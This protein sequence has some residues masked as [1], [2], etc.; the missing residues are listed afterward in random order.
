[1]PAY[2]TSGFA[3]QG[4]GAFAYQG[5]T[6]AVIPPSGGYWD[7]GTAR[8][9]KRRPR[10]EVEEVIDEVA[11]LQ[12]DS[13]ENDALRQKRE[14]QLHLRIRGL[15]YE[16]RHLEALAARREEMIHEALALEIQ[17]QNQYN[18]D[19]IAAIMIIAALDS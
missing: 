18:D 6:T 12:V 19:A 10:N 5:G 9:K 1:M 7:Y 14:L 4:S 2:Q 8:E 13:L 15:K 11:A 3:Y 16:T 17:M